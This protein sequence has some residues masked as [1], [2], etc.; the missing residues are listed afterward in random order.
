[1]ARLPHLSPL[2]AR[3]MSTP[4]L[5]S[6]LFPYTTLFRSKIKTGQKDRFLFTN[7]KFFF[8]IMLCCNRCHFLCGV[9]ID[10]GLPVL[11]FFVLD[12]EHRFHLAVWIDLGQAPADVV[13]V[14]NCQCMLDHVSLCLGISLITSIQVI[15]DL[16]CSIYHRA[17]LFV[18][19]E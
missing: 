9:T 1:L 16:V 7:I 4:R 18:G 15:T 3:L 6:T 5:K 2:L 17:E 11:H 8:C 14:W 19:I 12:T 13:V 10:V